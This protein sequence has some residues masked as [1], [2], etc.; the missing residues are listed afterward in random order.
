MLVGKLPKRREYFDALQ[1]LMY[2]EGFTPSEVVFTGHVDHDDLLAC[3]AAADVF[4][5]TSDYEGFGLVV[6]E[7]MSAGL[8][9]V[10]C[11]AGGVT[12]L[13]AHGST[14]YLVAPGDAGAVAAQLAGLLDYDGLRRE[15]GAAGAARAS[16][17]FDAA[18]MADGYLAVYCGGQRAPSAGARPASV[19]LLKSGDYAGYLR[20]HEPAL[21]LPYRIDEL[22]RHGLSVRWTDAHLRP[23]WTLRPLAN[24]V[25][26]VERAAAP[27]LQTMLMLPTIA[28]SDAVLA[29]FES[30]GN[31]LAFAR[32]AP[33]PPLRRPGLVVVSCWLADLLVRGDESYRRRYRTSYR[34]VD[35]LVYFSSN[36]TAIFAEHLGL[37]GERLRF[38]PF[39]IDEA[40]YAPVDTPDDPAYVL[41]VGRD[42]ARDWATFF[43]AMRR[44]GLP[45]RVLCRP[46][47]IRDLRVPDNVEVLGYT[48]EPTYRALLGGARVSVVATTPRAYPSGQSVVLESMAMARA[49]VVTD[50]PA[51]RD[52]LRPGRTALAVPPGDAEALADAI[53]TAF[54]D[55]ELRSRLGGEARATVEQE[56]TAARMWSA[57]AAVIQEVA[58]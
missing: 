6:V 25:Q 1:A 32:R 10:A 56:F 29:L 54:E 15:M 50:T 27:C 26:M 40:R 5:S 53:S 41:A 57:I 45:A 12:D 39:G 20:S 23:P 52:Y 24:A 33:L 34:H 37:D 55:R 7:A 48:A 16:K 36:Q 47:Q 19:A 13:V 31:L 44:C 22:E 58:R 18:A 2:E 46:S 51:L 3:Y 17:L 11:A 21:A 38:V 35:R 43:E 4:V 8:P 30:E 9:V 42:A 49:T 14:G 28:R